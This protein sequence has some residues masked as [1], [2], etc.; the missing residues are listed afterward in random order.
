[1]YCS[2]HGNCTML[3]CYKTDTHTQSLTDI[4]IK[5]VFFCSFYMD[6]QQNL[7]IQHDPKLWTCTTDCSHDF[8]TL[9]FSI[10]FQ[11]TWICNS[12]WPYKSKLLNSTSWIWWN[13]YV[14]LGIILLLKVP[15]LS[16]RISCVASYI[17]CT[18]QITEQ[19]TG[20][21]QLKSHP[22]QI[23]NYPECRWEIT[24]YLFPWCQPVEADTITGLQLSSFEVDLYNNILFLKDHCS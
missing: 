5:Y 14:Q 15:Q 21:L 6:I 3:S 13:Q 11:P 19:N 12:V 8:S 16:S 17:H 22:W 7:R 9:F 23:S 18:G 1:M 4:R 20:E 10:C 24:Y 2:K